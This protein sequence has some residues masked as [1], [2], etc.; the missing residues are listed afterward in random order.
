MLENL[1]SPLTIRGKT[2][3]NRI[4]SAPNGPEGHVEKNGGFSPSELE[5][6]KERSMGGFASVTIGETAVNETDAKRG[7]YIFTTDFNQLSGPQ[8]E[9]WKRVIEATRIAGDNL[10]MIQL[11]HC[12]ATRANSPGNTYA[13]GP[14]AYT[15]EDGVEVRAMTKDDIMRICNDFAQAAYYLKQV[16]ADGIM[17]HA[18]HGWLPSQFLS[19]MTNH[20]KDEYGGSLDNRCRFSVELVKA[21]RDK[22]GDDFIIEVR[23]SGAERCE[24]GCEM[25]ETAY[26]CQKIDGIADIINVSSGCYYDGLITRT[27]SNLFDPH[28]VNLPQAKYIK[29]HTKNLKVTLVGGINDPEA[30]DKLIADGVID[31]IALGR[32]GMCDT[33][34]AK[35]CIEGRPEDILRCAR[36][37]RCMGGQDM[38]MDDM[39]ALHFIAP[40]EDGGLPPIPSFDCPV[41]ASMNVHKD[42]SV[43]PEKPDPKRVLVVGGGPAGLQAALTAAERG[44]T[45]TLCEKTPYLGGLMRY[46]DCDH[47]KADLRYKK[48]QLIRWVREAGV[49]ILLETPCTPELIAEKKPEAVIIAV[50]S[51][52]RAPEIPGAENLV[53]VSDMYFGAP[54]GQNVVVMGGG[55]TGCEAAIWLADAGKNVTLL[56]RSPILVKNFGRGYRNILEEQ[57]RKFRIDCRKNCAISRITP[58]HVVYVDADGNERMIHAD[59]VVCATGTVADQETVQEILAMAKDI[60]TQ[61]IGDCVKAGTMN[62]ALG[63]GIEAA[64]AI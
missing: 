11:A 53:N 13:I 52:Y 26:F 48:D 22:V 8:F 57:I 40:G 37:M 1:L 54:V 44:H 55:E 38:K 24:G 51:K 7:P 2:F 12:G 16:G 42:L 62:R 61:V 31:F 35:K 34:F 29:E 15:T 43:Y 10:V 5:H 20:R 27:Y 4:T 59:S 30:A 32:Q 19:A 41:N 45:V 63:E 14:D 56:S 21:I 25:A 47:F 33:E 23:V 28:F 58:E 49:E 9:G 17:V 46:T 3:K 64:Y 36:C 39:A 6:L 18:A 50:G 60:P